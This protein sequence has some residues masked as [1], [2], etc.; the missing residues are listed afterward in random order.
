MDYK[1]VY[2][3]MADNQHVYLILYVI[4]MVYSVQYV[5]F[6]QVAKDPLGSLCT[7]MCH[8]FLFG[9]IG[10]FIISC[11]P[12]E[13]QIVALGF[14]IFACLINFYFSYKKYLLQ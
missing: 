12:V 11:A 10:G 5:G 9:V 4:G 13:L 7:S 8:G 3:Y 6:R 2:D 14:L 1:T